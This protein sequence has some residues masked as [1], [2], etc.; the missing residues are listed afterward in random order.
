MTK[1]DSKQSERVEL[2]SKASDRRYLQLDSAFRLALHKWLDDA[3]EITN[4][5]LFI[6]S[7]GSRY[8]KIV[9]G[10]SVYAFIDPKNGDVLFPG[11]WN[12]PTKS[13]PIRGNIYQGVGGVERFSLK[14][15]RK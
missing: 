15:L 13:S 9:M 4:E 5:R 6:Y 7:V 14:Y 8:V 1:Q 2:N 3:S 11:T 10:T 12:G